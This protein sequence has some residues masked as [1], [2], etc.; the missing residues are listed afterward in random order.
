MGKAIFLLLVFSAAFTSAPQEPENMKGMVDRHNFW[1]KK[2]NVPDLKWSPELSAF[3]QD[4]AD[5]LAAEGCNMEHR[6]RSGKWGSSY[7]ENIYWSSGM[8]NTPDVVVDNWASEIENFDARTGSCKGGVCG[9][10]T[11]VVWK[12]TQ[13]VGCGMAKCGDQEIWVCNYDPPGN[14]VGEKPY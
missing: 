12:N 7:G 1:R 2:V 4:W 6:P 3:A 13:R 10:Y 5:K 11:Q 8:K 9:H 14:W